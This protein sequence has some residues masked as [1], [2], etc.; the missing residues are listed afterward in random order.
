MPNAKQPY[1][2]VYMAKI[3]PRRTSRLNAGGSSSKKL[4]LASKSK[5]LDFDAGSPSTLKV[6]EEPES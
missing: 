5:M 3:D 1:G 6:T 4:N 2:S